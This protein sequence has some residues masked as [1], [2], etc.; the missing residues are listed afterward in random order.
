MESKGLVN[1]NP[2]ESTQGHIRRSYST[3]DRSLSHRILFTPKFGYYYPTFCFH[4]VP[5]DE[6]SVNS[7]DYLD[8]LSLKAP[9]K[10]AINKEKRSFMVPMMALLPF[11]WD[12]IYTL[13][14]AGSDV[15]DSANSVLF[16]FHT[17][18]VSFLKNLLL[19]AAVNVPEFT[20]ADTGVGQV[21]VSQW[22][23]AALRALVLNEYVFSHGSLLNL[24][25][26]KVSSWLDIRSVYDYNAVPAGPFD[27]IPAETFSFDSI[28]DRLIDAMFRYVSR[29]NVV[30]PDSPVNR[31]YAI[32]G[33]AGRPTRFSSPFSLLLDI[34]R[35]NPTAFISLIA[36]DFGDSGVTADNLQPWYT[37]LWQQSFEYFDGNLNG[38]S[39]P[40]PISNPADIDTDPTA[41][42]PAVFNYSPLA[43]Y[44]M[45]CHHFY[46]NSNYDF[47]YSADIFRQYFASLWANLSGLLDGGSTPTFK[48]NGILKPYD[49]LSGA[50]VSRLLYKTSD[51]ALVTVSYS[52]L[53]AQSPQ[54][55][56]LYRLAAWAALFS[57]RRSLRYVDY[58]VGARPTPLAPLA[59]GN[60]SVNNNMVDVIDI[61]RSIQL[62]R[63]R[64]AS[65]RWRNK[66]EEY[67][68]G[69]F[70]DRPAPDYHNPF[71]LSSERATV[72]G[73]D[74]QNTGAA[75]TE[76]ANSRTANFV[77]TGGQF[78]YT[79]HNNDNHPCIYMQII[80][81]DVRRSYGSTV[82]RHYLHANRFDMFNPALQYIGDQP[83]YLTELGYNPSS[84]S[85]SMAFG[86]KTRDAEYKEMYDQ[87]SGGFIEN[88][89]GWA[90]TDND[91]RTFSSGRGPLAVNNE[92]FI[93][94]YPCELDQFFLS[95]TGH[96]LGSRFHF[97]MITD[98]SVSAK[99]PMA[100]DPQVL[101]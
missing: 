54:P 84:S 45:I 43:A 94:S 56:L 100:I 10:S 2:A 60:I 29:I 95:L 78:T 25:N 51:D 11:N 79:F 49:W 65:I 61:T 15:P 59:N 13:P 57:Y 81:F 48:W 34:F 85:N 21:V 12:Q 68:D 96:S 52:N 66:I 26:F 63:L 19:L 33:P 87:C 89:P 31:S 71:A 30:V 20:L 42:S 44:Q 76:D 50:V 92:D 86:Y 67:V 14:S 8:S 17:N 18:G 62:Q 99:R 1:T 7:K 41:L 6:I 23:T 97:I 82:G 55:T 47:V 9:F 46:T 4:G 28:F 91:Q 40:G 73:D 75:Q 90:F 53:S 24:L 93:R 69:M 64:N 32:V 83:L 38:F 74:V 5:T 36:F 27:A 88:L 80:G 101:Q 37:A 70:G 39:Y 58:F 3:F 72:F 35:E 16:D 98:N 77:Q 22:Y